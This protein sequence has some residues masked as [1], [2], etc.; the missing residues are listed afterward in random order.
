MSA[1]RGAH[2]FAILSGK[3]GVGKTLITANVAAALSSTGVRTVVV[4]AD[5]GLANMDI[6]LGLTPS[7]TL[8][9]LL[10]GACTLDEILMKAPGGFDLLPAA[11]GILEATH[12]TAAMAGSLE[13]VLRKLDERYDAMLFDAGA[14][15]G[16]VVVFIAR[17]AHTL[18]I[19]VT[20]EPTSLTDAYATIKVLAT[21]YN[22][23]QFSLI[24][25]QAD[26]SR[27]EQTAEEIAGRLRQVISRFLVTDSQAPVQL[28]LV[29]AIPADP[30][31]AQAV[32]RQQL[33]AEADPHAPATRSIS[34]L[35][36]FLRPVSLAR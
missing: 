20:P 7:L 14:G 2:R 6:L 19:V 11:S 26:P 22:R 28:H 16:E 23:S 25:N 31:V 34:R 4:D 24:V 35:A 15:I 29:G 18:L 1:E 5:L 21:R 32:A 13:S 30:M 17:M 9:D 12:M 8:P 27:P 10:R 36:D 3:G 33:L